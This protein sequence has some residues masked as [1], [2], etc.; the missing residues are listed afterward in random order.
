MARDG[1]SDF[2]ELYG[3]DEKPPMG[4]SVLLGIQH[5]LA[6]LLPNIAPPLIIAGGI[7]LATGQTTFLVQM[8]LLFAG[9]ATVVQTSPIGPVGARLP[10]VM[11]TSFTF[12]G[13][14]IAI[15]TQ[16]GL[17]TAFG[18][19]I[20]GA[21]VEIA[22]GW[23]FEWFRSYFTPLVNGLIVV[24][25]GL[26]LIPTGMDYLAGGAD[27]ANY[28][29]LINLGVGSLVFVVAIL[30]NQ[31]FSGVLRILSL[32]IAIVGGYV[33]ALAV[34]M[35]DLS[36][37]GEAAWVA[38]PVPLRFGVAFEP[39][40][41]LI[42]GLIYITTTMETVGHI[43]ALTTVENRNPN[44]DELKGG[45]LADGVMSTI[46]GVFGAFPNTSFAQNIGVVT[47]TGVMSRFVVTIAGVILVLLGLVPKVGALISTIPY[48]V[49]GGATLVM[50]GM[51]LSSGFSILNDDV[52]INR[53]NMVIIAAAISLGLGV[54][55]RPDVLSQLP[56][57]AQT[58]LGNAVVMTAV[59]ALVL[60]NL[61]PK[62]DDT[63]SVDRDI[64]R[65]DPA[66]TDD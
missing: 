28:G 45:L 44:V 25:T 66:E 64:G 41:I 59:V 27:A 3:I 42:M 43:S 46:A 30:L 39:V 19:A 13:G 34:G 10:I 54:T 15:G 8:A 63:G 6:M 51:I 7:G 65:S 4:E 33:V 48:P 9:L 61:V 58:F 53:R 32:A 16:Y 60:D 14:L 50:F 18:A 36:P 29:A 5:V 40:P 11:G 47:F 37:I 20:V 17:A 22:I 2:G 38:V 31:L 56:Q 26:Y 35:V 62:R 55:V 52:P 12:V 49:L 23:K 1:Q 57:Q 24:I 21:F